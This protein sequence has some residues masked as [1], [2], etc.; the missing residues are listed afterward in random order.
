[1]KTFDLVT[2]EFYLYAQTIPYRYSKV[3]KFVRPC[4]HCNA[5]LFYHHK[6]KIYQLDSHTINHKV[7]PLDEISFHEL[8]D[9]NL[10]TGL[11]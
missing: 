2:G 3:L 1:M 9:S 8:E 5:Y 7:K 11:V 6:D 10:E 4:E